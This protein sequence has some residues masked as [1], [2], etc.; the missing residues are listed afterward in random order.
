MKELELQKSRHPCEFNEVK[1][2]NDSN[3]KN[4]SLLEVSGVLSVRGKTWP[5]EVEVSK[6]TT[7]K[8]GYPD[9]LEL[10]I[11]DNFLLLNTA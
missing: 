3:N 9:N 11:K 1:K 2:R 7:E 10:Q 4:L 5:L 6:L 8:T